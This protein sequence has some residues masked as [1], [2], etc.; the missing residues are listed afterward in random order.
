MLS[1]YVTLC[2]KHKIA[3]GRSYNDI[4]LKSVS[5][6]SERPRRNAAHRTL[7]EEWR[8]ARARIGSGTVIEP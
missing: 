2:V 7:G 5:R 8:R 3:D 6:V 4:K 1:R